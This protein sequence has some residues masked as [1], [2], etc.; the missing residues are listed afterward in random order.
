MP[1]VDLPESV[2]EDIVALAI[3][4][5]QS[6]DGLRH[7][8]TC[9]ITDN[10]GPN[11]VYRYRPTWR[12]KHNSPTVFYEQDFA[13]EDRSLPIL[14]PKSSPAVSLL[15]TSRY[16]HAVTRD[17]LIRRG[18]F[19]VQ[20]ED[21]MERF[22]DSIGKDNLQLVK[23]VDWTLLSD[24]SRKARSNVDPY[25]NYEDVVRERT[26]ALLRRLPL[27]LR[28]LRIRLP[29]PPNLE[30]PTLVTSCL[31]LDSNLAKALS[32][33]SDLQEL[34]L[35][36]NGYF[37]YLELF[38][39]PVLPASEDN[40]SLHPHP[41]HQPM[42]PA[43][44]RLYLRGCIR[45]SISEAQ[46]IKAFSQDQLPSLQTLQIDGLIVGRVAAE[47]GWPFTPAVLLAMHPLVEFEWNGFN[48]KTYSCRTTFLSELPLEKDL[49]ALKERHGQTLRVLKINYSRCHCCET[50]LCPDVT[51][52]MVM[53]F[54]DE[55][56]GLDRVHIKGLRVQVNEAR[57]FDL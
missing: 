6:F 36:R 57:A 22:M 32:R 39:V 27:R 37:I 13:T 33:F 24:I 11:T 10:P 9:Q 56:S 51:E 1:L 46:M 34:E 14:I 25:H 43:L 18:V 50:M 19:E 30:K 7:N 28:A 2:L 47:N 8:K 3:G 45:G 16:L 48:C 55:M 26:A 49:A 53:G 17:L 35:F 23:H 40:E 5:S 21:A 4:V 20:S 42:F 29:Q 38:W 52:D 15:L 44:R 54:L 41:L 31:W 12:T